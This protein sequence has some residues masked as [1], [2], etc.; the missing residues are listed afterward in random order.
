MKAFCWHGTGD[1]RID[2]VPDP[3]IEHPRD[4]IIK[5]TASGICGSDLHLLNGYV[6]T[7]ESGDILGHEPIGV[8]VEVG[9]DVTNLKRE[10]RV[11]VP[12]TIACGNCFFCKKQLF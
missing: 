12:F 9:R 11:V 1:V 7:T 6:P 5:V 10:D 3:K 2:A 8:V 4:A